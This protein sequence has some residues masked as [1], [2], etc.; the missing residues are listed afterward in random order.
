MSI[1]RQQRRYE[2]RKR[3]K[4]KSRVQNVVYVKHPRLPD[5]PNG[6]LQFPAIETTDPAA[7]HCTRIPPHMV[8]DFFKGTSELLKCLQFDIGADEGLGGKCMIRTLAAYQ[9]VRV[10][11]VQARIGIGGLIARVGPDPWRDVVAFCGPGNVGG[12]EPHSGV[13]VFHC[14]LCYENWIFDPSVGEW[15]DLDPVACELA[16]FGKALPVVQWDITLPSYWLKPTAE[17]EGAWRPHG[18][19]ELGKAWYGPF[20]GNPAALIKA[21]AATHRECGQQIADTIARNWNAYAESH[22]FDVTPQD[23]TVYPLQFRIRCAKRLEAPTP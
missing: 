3:E 16:A 11:N 21:F 4:K 5:Y 15:R 13:P 17:V 9:A 18:A 1:N 22:S 6:A 14:W 20:C 7:A 10:S 8:A 2:P 23:D 12:M 19:P